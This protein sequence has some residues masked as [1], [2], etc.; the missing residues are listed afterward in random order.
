MVEHLGHVGADL[1]ARRIGPPPLAELLAFS[2]QPLPR[3]DNGRP[4]SKRTGHQQLAAEGLFRR[5]QWP[6]R[7]M[8]RSALGATA[9]LPSS[10]TRG[11]EN[12][13]RFGR[14]REWAGARP[15]NL[16]PAS[17]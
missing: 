3:G 1:N 2:G 11:S 17:M 16:A 15:E 9:G 4:K 5:F 6:G 7:R 13:Y 12:C 14:F 8:G 10:A